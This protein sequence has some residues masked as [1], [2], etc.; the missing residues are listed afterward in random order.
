MRDHVL[1]HNLFVGRAEA[2][3]FAEELGIPPIDKVAAQNWNREAVD[4]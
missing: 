3:R 1:A 4:P 2:H